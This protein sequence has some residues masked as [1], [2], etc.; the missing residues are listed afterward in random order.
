MRIALFHG[1]IAERTKHIHAQRSF[2]FLEEQTPLSLVKF[3]GCPWHT[4]LDALKG[5]K[6]I[7]FIHFPIRS[8]R[9]VYNLNL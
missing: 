5:R 8:I 7:H 1:I 2:R 9:N 6:L 4:F 3:K